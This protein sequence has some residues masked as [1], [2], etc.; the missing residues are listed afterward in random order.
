VGFGFG[1]IQSG[2]FLLEAHRS[3]NFSRLVVAEVD[4]ALVDAVRGGG[5]RYA[6]NM[7]H[8]NHIEQLS[9]DGIEIYNPTDPGDR[10]Q[11]IDAVAEAGEMATALPSVSF[12]DV[13]GPGSVAAI[14]GKGLAARREP[15]PT[16][17]YAAEN[18][19]HAAEHLAEAV[20]R[21]CPPDA[22][23][24]VQTLNTVI[25]K[26]SGVIND[27][28]TMAC[29]GLAALAPGIS[30][31]IL[32]EAFNR[33]LVS[34]VA[35]P[36]RRGIDVFIEKGD[37]LPF[38]E[39]KLYGHN[40]IHALIGYLAEHKGFDT[41]ADAGQDD[42]IMSVARKAFLDESGA[43]LI[44]RHAALCDE[45]FT[46]NGYRAYADDLLQRMTCPFLND[47]VRRITRDHLRKLAWNDRLFG[48]MRLALDAGI[49][50]VNL[51]LGAAG[52][53]RSLAA[54]RNELDAPPR[55]LPNS[56]AEL[57]QQSLAALLL[58]IWADDA[59]A[60]APALV[61]L[62]RQGLQALTTG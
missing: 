60:H 5:N 54:R 55:N 30:R 33:I 26:M 42:W 4:A 41:V 19:N 57:T 52:A 2:L 58:E 15:T 59:D 1:P 51:A 45:L 17:L 11:L 35:V 18:H 29:L 9:V 46:P 32:V 24:Q 56:P 47:L 3:G 25:G 12:Y 10:R 48:T 39:A 43:A 13:G 38:E 50:P 40:A 7:A 61:N 16:L 53:V 14:I 8:A 20:G 31:A 49:E 44:Q 21:H 6:V 62:T 36:A 27:A 34:R 28:D 22:L 37:L 23:G